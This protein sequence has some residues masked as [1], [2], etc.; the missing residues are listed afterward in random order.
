MGSVTRGTALCLHQ[1]LSA[2]MDALY[3][4]WLQWKN[5][6]LS[7]FPPPTPLAAAVAWLL[8]RKGLACI[9]DLITGSSILDVCEP[10]DR[11][12]KTSD[13]NK[14]KYVCN[15]DRAGA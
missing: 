6:I 10:N 15:I 8:L 14:F 11:S 3:I 5:E 9:L 2:G 1:Q 7:A 13:C 12:G 4:E